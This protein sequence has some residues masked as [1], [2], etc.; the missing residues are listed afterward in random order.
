MTARDKRLSSCCWTSPRRSIRADII[1][2]PVPR[3]GRVL[4]GARLMSDNT[5][6]TLARFRNPRN[7]RIRRPVK[8]LVKRSLSAPKSHACSTS[9]SRTSAG[10]IPRT[11]WIAPKRLHGLGDEDEGLDIHRCPMCARIPVDRDHDGTESVIPID[12]NSQTGPREGEARRAW[13]Y[14]RGQWQFAA[15]EGRTISQV[16][17]LPV[18]SRRFLR[19]QARPQLIR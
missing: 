9:I 16:S 19:D 3:R 6:A 12:R 5:S 1:G 11:L 17:A 14:I 8:A 18:D 4:Q 2:S 7:V 15:I 13:P 10:Q